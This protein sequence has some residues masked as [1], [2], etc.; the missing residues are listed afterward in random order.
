MLSKLRKTI[1][2]HILMLTL[3]DAFKTNGI[4]EENLSKKQSTLKQLIYFR[5]ARIPIPEKNT[6]VKR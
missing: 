4:V 2:L 3:V 6:N 5:I 1:H